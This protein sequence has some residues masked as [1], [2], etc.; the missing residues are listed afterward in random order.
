MLRQLLAITIKELKLIC[1]DRGV[2]SVLF[3]LPIVFV[4]LMTYAGVGNQSVASAKIL[5]VNRDQGLLA[6]YIVDHLREEKGLIVVDQIDGSAIQEEESETLLLK[7]SSAYSLVLIFPPNF[8]SA[9]QAESKPLVK[10]IAD[11]ATGGSNLNPIERLIKMYIMNVAGYVAG[12][13]A[14]N[15]KTSS[16]DTPISDAVHF[17]RIAPKGMKLTRPIS[18]EEQNVPGYTIFGIFFIVQV[19]GTTILRERE[20]GTYDRLMTAPISP[21]R[22][23]LGKLAP[24][25]LVNLVQVA[26]MFLIGSLV[27]NIA[28]EKC[29]PGLL[30]VTFATAA[31]ANSLGLLIASISKTTEQ[32][33]PLSSLILICMATVG[34]I[35]IP[36]FEMPKLLQ[37]L[38]FLT[39]H[40]WA[41]KGFQDV[42]VRGYTT[43][44]ILPTVAVL[45]C[46]SIAFYTIALLKIYSSQRNV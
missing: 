37:S 34:G 15:T 9:L 33:G 2:L 23:L 35:F 28:L 1:R 44:A 43:S 46:F 14:G 24:F 38:S 39:P 11:P 10:F 6:S 36:F 32:M 3:I 25:Y 41:L 22:I 27:F 18:A 45:L 42:L 7:R 26:F 17:A 16:I 29:I 21:A 31:T 8:S 40:A 30:L 20:G 19:I 12:A 13:K 4:L 5:I